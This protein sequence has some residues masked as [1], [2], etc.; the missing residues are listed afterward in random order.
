MP[1]PAGPG[2][3]ERLG[4]CPVS[5]R[6]AREEAAHR[7]ADA[8]WNVFPCQPGDKK[9]ATPHGFLDGTTSHKQIEAWWRND[10]RSNL[11][12]ATG[13]PGPDVLDVDK[14]KDGS[15]FG[16]F[17]RL[18]REG[19]VRE[20]MAIVRTPSGGFHAYYRGTNQRN[21]HIPGEYV[22]FRSQGGYVVAPPS[23]IAGHTYEVA[24]KQPSSDTFNWAAAKQLLAPQPERQ[25]YR[26]PERAGDRPRDLS[27]LPGWVA[28]QP[29][30]NRNHG[31]FWASCRAV[32]AGDT[33]TLDSLAS[34]ARAAGLDDRE[35][36]RTIASAQKT[37]GRGGGQR[38]FEHSRAV[39]PAARELD[40]QA[41]AEAGALEPRPASRPAV[42]S[43]RPAGHQIPGTWK[44]S[45]AS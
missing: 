23:R 10:P 38:P 28:S 1:A 43:H 20:P 19:L 30:G 29:E 39:A 31:L 13:A 37:A 26:A 2:R 12:L 22:D 11:G 3:R 45:H 40:L 18:K 24:Q 32:E 8:G 4:R 44:E 42:A 17:N 7:Y 34:A 35:V 9:P 36:D 33:A 27:H 15:G 25:P 6:Q 14:H 16:A 41:E 5:R 21:G